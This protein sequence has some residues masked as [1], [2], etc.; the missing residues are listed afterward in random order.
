MTHLSPRSSQW[1]AN[2]ALKSLAAA[3]WSTFIF[4]GVVLSIASPESLGTATAS[5]LVVVGY[6]SIVAA[7]VLAFL[8][9]RTI[10]DLQ[11]TGRVADVVGAAS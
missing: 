11:E 2:L 6:L 7:G 9:V 5:I 8:M 3:W 4:A 10:S 1:P